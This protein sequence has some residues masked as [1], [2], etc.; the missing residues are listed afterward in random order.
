ERLQAHAVMVFADELDIHLWPK[1]GA[2]WMPKGTQL[3]VMTPGQNAQHY[4]ADALNLA[5]GEILHGRSTRKT[6]ALFRDLLTVLDHAYPAPRMTRIYVVVDHYCIHKAKAVE[7]WIDS[8]PRF[9]RLWLPTYCP[10]ANPLERAFGDVHDQCTRNHK[11]KRLRDVVSDVE[12]HLRQNGPWF[13]NLSRLYDAPEV[14]AAVT[15]L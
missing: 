14:T 8:H 6:N 4:L 9:V 11:R 3:E 2:A 15:A 13:Y 12:R 10:Q 1:V 5:T 7:Q